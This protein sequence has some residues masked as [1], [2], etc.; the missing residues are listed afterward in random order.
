MGYYKKQGVDLNEVAAGEEQDISKINSAG[1][2][3]LRVQ[4]SWG[5]CVRYYN[6][7]QFDDLRDELNALWPEFYADA[8]KPQRQEHGKIDKNISQALR[9]RAKNIKRKKAWLFYNFRYKHAVYRK[10]L[11]LKTLEKAQGLGKAYIDPDADDWE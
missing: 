1:L 11:F 9:D 8:T 6:N 5:S 7:G 4:N 10:W 2:I 3:N